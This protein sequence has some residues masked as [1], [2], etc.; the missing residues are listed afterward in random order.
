MHYEI[1]LRMSKITS[2]M[3]SMA[4]SINASIFLQKEYKWWRNVFDYT[5]QILEPSLV[6]TS[7]HFKPVA[8]TLSAAKCCRKSHKCNKLDGRK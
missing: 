8:I 1:T 7:I 3:A 6:T 4:A 2:Q 5:Y